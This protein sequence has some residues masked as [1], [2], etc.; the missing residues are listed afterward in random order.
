MAYVTI[1]KDLSRIQSKVLF[2]L[3]KRQV[4]CFG[5]AA[6]V[7]VPL[8]FLAKAS[9]GTTTAALCMILVN[10]G[11]LKATQGDTGHAE[12][13][14][15]TSVYAHILDEDRK[16]NAQKFESAFYANP[17]LRAVRPPEEPK[18]PAPATLDLEALVEQLRQSPELAN[19]LAAL[20]SAAPGGR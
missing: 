10:H 7:G 2:G 3:T 13:D 20:L 8:F 15:I 19:T 11:D 4:I 16:I 18:E 1:P 6:L 14:M 17:N 12:I 5:A 9:L